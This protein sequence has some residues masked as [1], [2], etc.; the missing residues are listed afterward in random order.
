M[1]EPNL[2]NTSD[3]EFEVVCGSGYTPDSTYYCEDVIL[4]VCCSHG[5]MITPELIGFQVETY[6]FRIPCAILEQ[7]STFT[8]RYLVAMT[9]SSHGLAMSNPIFI[10]G[11]KAED[12]R[13]LLRVLLPL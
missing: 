7:S 3:D 2:S 11:Y 1:T 13:Q 5:E 4:L 8:S 9:G 6:L 10:K 12:F